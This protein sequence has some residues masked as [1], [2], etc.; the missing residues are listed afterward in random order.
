MKTKQ[1]LKV[2]HVIAWIVFIALC[3]KT[4]AILISYFVSI[5]NPEAAKNLYEGLNLFEYYNH[6]F[7]QYSFIIGYK[8]LLFSVEAYI[9]FLVTKLLSGLN[10]EK[11]FNFNVQKL[12]QK[13]SY[14][15]F[16]LWILAIVH[17]TQVQYLGK[18]YRFTIDLFS[19]DFIFLAGIIFI[20]AQIVKRGIEIQSENELTI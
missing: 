7:L 14:S 13:I 4:G 1:L 18:K 2:M 19:S 8:V 20:F 15:I 10:L 17:N 6:S 11:P 16:Y 9:A 5:S 3:I 12:M